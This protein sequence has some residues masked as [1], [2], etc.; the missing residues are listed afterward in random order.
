MKSICHWVSL[1]SDP[2]TRCAALRAG[3]P[4]R[5]LRRGRS[6]LAIGAPGSS[7]CLTEGAI[8][9]WKRLHIWTE[10]DVGQ[11]R[12]FWNANPFPPT[13]A[14]PCTPELWQVGSKSADPGPWPGRPSP[15]RQAR[16]W[17]GPKAEHPLHEVNH[18]LRRGTVQRF[19]VHDSWTGAPLSRLV[20]EPEPRNAVVASRPNSA[21]RRGAEWEADLGQAAGPIPAVAGTKGP[22]RP[23]RRWRGYP[24]EGACSWE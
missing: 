18:R 2:E 5:H 13:P 1:G 15:E 14:G 17:A 12:D 10:G 6:A 21:G 11:A 8:H 16:S 19:T 23:S 24:A 9:L 7:C 22:L 20:A 3:R 4:A